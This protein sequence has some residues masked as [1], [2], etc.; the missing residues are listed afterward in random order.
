MRMTQVLKLGKFYSFPT[1]NKN[2]VSGMEEM[3]KRQLGSRLTDL[4]I[5]RVILLIIIMLVALSLLSPVEV[6]KSDRNAVKLLHEFN[7]KR[8]QGW[9]SM[10]DVTKRMFKDWNWAGDASHFDQKRLVFLKLRPAEPFDQPVRINVPE[11]YATLRDDFFAEEL[12]KV[13]YS[14]Y[15]TLNGSDTLFVT[16]AWFNRRPI[17]IEE[18]TFNIGLSIFVLVLTVAGSILFSVDAHRLVSSPIENMVRMAY[19]ASQV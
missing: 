14:D 11:V 3:R 8:P 12:R 4:T 7:Q 16:E 18:T 10:I 6:D 17:I 13:R 15:G 5:R 19:Q 1:S 9:E 2:S